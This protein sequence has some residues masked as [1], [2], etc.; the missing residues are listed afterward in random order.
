ME[1][2]PRLHENMLHETEK[3][4]RATGMDNCAINIDAMILPDESVSIIEAARA[5]RSDGIPEVISGYTGRDYYSCIIDAALGRPI[6]PFD[7]THGHTDG[8][9]ASV[10][11][12]LPA[13][14]ARYAIASPGANT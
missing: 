4:I 6:A 1:V 8:L 10:H 13:F 14:S 7:L 5:L 11:R 9:A 12:A 3:I 2:S